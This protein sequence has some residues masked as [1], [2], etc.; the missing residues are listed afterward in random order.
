M[1][2]LREATIEDV[3]TILRFIQEL[4]DYE[5]EPDAAQATPADIERTIFSD[6]P[7]AEVVI[8]ELDG[9]PR[10]FALYFYNYS[11]WLGKPGLFLEDLYVQPDARGSGLGKA[12]LTRLAR[13]ARD[14][15]CGRMEWAVLDWN[16]PAISFYRSLGASSMDGW[17]TFRLD[18]A[19][20]EALG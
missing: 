13:I 9:E 6:K 4:A 16:T 10:G 19:A 20:L 8:G 1:I 17:T 2:S 14:G 7:Y 15:G 12:L 18:E 5:K 3:P 11:T